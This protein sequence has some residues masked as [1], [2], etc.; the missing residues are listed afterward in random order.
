MFGFFV[1]TLVATAKS[2]EETEVNQQGGTEEVAPGT[3][4]RLGNLSVSEVTSN[5]ARLSWSVPSGNFDS[6]SIQYKDA[7]G[8]P[9][10]IPVA[11]GSHEVIVP[12]LAPSHKY[13]FNLYGISGRQRL[14]P[15]SVNTVTG[16][17]GLL[18]EE[19]HNSSCFPGL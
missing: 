18:P 6:F 4:L 19:N 9:Q 7:E 16:Q 5:T 15:I 3:E 1:L 2:Q 14:G 10:A 11:G 8:R 17:H 13:R 12:N